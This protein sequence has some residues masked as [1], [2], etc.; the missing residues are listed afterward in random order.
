[1]CIPWLAYTHHVSGRVGYWGNSGGLSLYWMSSPDPTQLGEWHAVHTVL[2]DGAL[3]GYRP[4]FRQ[5]RRLPPPVEDARLTGLALRQA[6]GHPAKYVRN[7]AANVG[8]MTVG[9]PFGVRVPWW[10]VAG[11]TLSN[12]ALLIALLGLRRRHRRRGPRRRR[13]E[14]AAFAA[15]AGMA[16]VV[17]LLP[18]TEPRM[19]I[20]VVPLLVWLAAARHH[21]VVPASDG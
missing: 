9:W 14:T 16:I 8:R 13:P 15:F 1:L 3:T 20:P 21:S 7:L 12:I 6:A 10:G 17:H 5:L 4:L 11:V 19:L 2:R 18:S